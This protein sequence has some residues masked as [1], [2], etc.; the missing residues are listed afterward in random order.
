MN[1]QYIINPIKDEYLAH[2]GIKGQRWG[3]RHYQNPDGTLTPAGKERYGVGRD[4]EMSSAGKRQF[5]VDQRAI[6]G[7]HMYENGE[8]INSLRNK[9][10]AVNKALA[11]VGTLSVAAAFAGVSKNRVMSGKEVAARYALLGIG[12]TAVGG[13]VANSVARGTQI[14]NMKAYN[15]NGP[16]RIT[17]IDKK[18]K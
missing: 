3:Y 13:V 5:K 4:G 17:P 1:K 10:D 7:Q 16:K 6:K 12:A 14:R 15:V 9:R 18:S 8:G 2:H 11:I